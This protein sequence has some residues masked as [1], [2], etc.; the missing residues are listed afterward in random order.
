MQCNSTRFTTGTFLDFLGF[1]IP[2]VSLVPN[3]ILWQN[4]TTMVPIEI[5]LA[6]ICVY[7]YVSTN[8]TGTS[9]VGAI[10]MAQNEQKS[11]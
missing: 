2:K 11:F 3:C 1:M 5:N 7:K 8:K 9:K 10:S 6:Y 4:Y